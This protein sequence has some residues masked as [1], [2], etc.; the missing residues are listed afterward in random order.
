MLKPLSARSSHIRALALTLAWGAAWSTAAHAT[1]GYLMDGYGVKSLGLAGVSVALPLDALAAASNPGGTGLI[2]NRFDI[3]ASLFAPDYNTDIVG[4]GFGADGHYGGSLKKFLIPEIGYSHTLGNSFAAGVSIYGNG[5]ITTEYVNNPFGAFG[6]KGRAG[7]ALQQLFVTPSLAWKP[8]PSQSLGIAVDFTRQTFSAE[9]LNV[10]A[11]SSADAANLTD[12][13]TDTSTGVGVKLGWT[14]QLLPG[15]TAGLSYSSR[16]GT[17]RFKDYRG[18]FAQGG[19][20]DVPET[21]AIGLSYMVTPGLT[22]AIDGQRIRYSAVSA[23]GNPLANLFAGNPLGSANGP[24]FGWQD[25]TVVKVG[26]QYDASADWTV[27]IGY[28]HSGQPIPENQTFF[29]ILAPAVIQSH[30]AIG[31]T[32]KVSAAGELSV[33]YTDAIKGSVNGN[34]SIP[35]PFGGGNANISLGENIFSVAYG[36]KL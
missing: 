5:G 4:N 29:N 20:F 30:V 16:I 3:G 17:S 31:A 28:S 18:R 19:S 26:V 7:V 9:G 25:V 2:G 14:G 8:A 35:G 15:L 12:R 23:V 32:W 6:G 24:G 10:F 1:N 13:G 11:T 22:V 33:A 36:W 27:R 21:D 34:Q